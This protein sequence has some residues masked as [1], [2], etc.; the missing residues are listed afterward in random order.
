AGELGIL[1]ANVPEE[2]G[3]PGAD[4]LYNAI[5]IEE[6]GRAGASG[7]GSAFMVHSEIVAPYILHGTNEAIRREWLPKMV[8]G[9]K[10]GALG[11][12]E[13]HAGSD[14]KAIRTRAI[15]DGDDY[16]INGQKIFISN[17]INCDFIV[18]ACKTD[19]DA[20]DKGVSLV[21][22]EADREGFDKGRQLEK[23]GLHAAD[24]AELFFADVRVPVT[25]RVSEEHGGFKVMMANLIQERLGQAVRAVTVCEAAIEWTVKYTRDREAFGQTIFDFQNTQFVLAELDAR[26]AGA[27]AFTDACMMQMDKGTLDG[28]TM[29]QLKLVTMELQGEVLD[30]CLQFFGGYGYM[31]EYPIARAFIDARLNRIAGGTMEV[32]KHIIGKDLAKRY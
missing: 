6:F 20:A 23:I 30:K 21:L 31:M 28:V 32:M 10:V 29:A 11:L 14:L 3:G 17:G 19:P 13:P 27:R 15:R 12:T 2:Y 4:W 22:V 9:E 7:P 8:T 5:I 24:T 1:C 18:L 16:V 25:N 26:T